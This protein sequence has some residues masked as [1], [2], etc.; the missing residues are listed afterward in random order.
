MECLYWL[1]KVENI[2]NI[3][4]IEFGGPKLFELIFRFRF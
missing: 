2:P 1:I 3:I 4:I